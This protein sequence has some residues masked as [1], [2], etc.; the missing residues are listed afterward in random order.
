MGDSAGEPRRVSSPGLF[1]ESFS[2]AVDY[3]GIQVPFVDREKI[4][5]IGICGSGGFSLAAAAVDTRIKAVATA[6]MY[7]ITDIRGMMGLSKDQLDKMK[8]DLAQQRWEDYANGMPEYKPSFPTKPYPSVDAL[9]KTDPITNEWQRFYAVP[10][11]FHQNARGNFTTTSNQA[12]LQ[13]SALD[14]IDEITPRPILFIFGDRAHS[15]S[16][17]ERAYD[18]ANEPKEKYIVE[19]CEHID[20]YDRVDKIPLAKL[21]SFFKQHL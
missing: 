4:R 20:L 21:E 10:R 7:D 15:R 13:F 2:A 18:M 16:F 5:V 17:S 9:P 8:D 1:A 11:G 3:L 6:S 19:D 12:M 14:Y